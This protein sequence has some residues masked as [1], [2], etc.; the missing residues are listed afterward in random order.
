MAKKSKQLVAANDSNG[1]AFRPPATTSRKDLFQ[2]GSDDWVRNVIYRLVQALSRLV[3]CREAFGRKLNLTGSQFAILMGVAYRQGSAGMSIAA[4]SSYVGLAAPHVTTEVGRL[5]EIGLLCKRPNKSDRRG[6]L[7]S[8]SRG[9][10]NAVRQVAPM[11]RA[12]NDILLRGISRQQL[13]AINEFAAVLLAN[14]EYAQA[15]IRVS[16]TDTDVIP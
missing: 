7:V 16:Q 3:T 12:I 6:V 1:L 11:V 5:I 13:E 9:G 4:L 10:E 14:S 8:L 2:G 15:A